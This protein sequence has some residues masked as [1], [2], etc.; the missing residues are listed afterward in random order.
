MFHVCITSLVN[1]MIIATVF[2]TVT[3]I[4]K[5]QAIFAI[6]L[7]LYVVIGGVVLIIEHVIKIIGGAISI[8]HQLVLEEPF[9]LHLADGHL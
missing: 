5:S 7:H 4:T 1:I 3:M 2:I 8:K 9:D 6:K